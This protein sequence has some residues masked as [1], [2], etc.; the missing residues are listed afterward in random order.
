MT[1]TLIATVVGGLILFIWQFL[2]WS[3]L[4]IHGSEMQ[5]TDKQDN[6]LAVL[7]QENLA[8]GSYFLPNVDSN[9][10][11]EEREAYVKENTGKPWA[12]L[13]YHKNMQNNMAMNMVRGL[14]IDLISVFLLIFILT[15][16]PNNNLKLSVMTSLAVGLIGYFTIN[17]LN[18]IWFEESSLASLLDAFVQWGLV[19]VWL[20]W[21]LN[22]N[23]Q[24]S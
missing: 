19:G 5:Y 4:N 10:T 11:M 8:E 14:V 7:A 15:S 2:S 21:F 23:K 12:K 3:L 1:K 9:A 16:N 6:I 13:S 24:Q 17:Y 18:T 20:G 22:R